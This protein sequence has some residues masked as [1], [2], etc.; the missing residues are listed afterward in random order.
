MIGDEIKNSIIAF[1][2]AAEIDY[3]YSDEKKL[4]LLRDQ[5]IN[6][7]LA[8]VNVFVELRATGFIVI[9]FSP[10]NAPKETQNE[11]VRYL[12]MIN[13]S[14]TY[15]YFSLDYSDGEVK[16]LHSLDCTDIT[17]LTHNMIYLP[18]VMSINSFEKYGDGLCSLMMG[19][20]DAETE[21]TKA[22]NT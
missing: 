5:R 20:S 18:L 7:K 14:K 10:R 22:E 9:S 16:W 6:S 21:F 4:F 17:Q 15:G 2:N 13:H 3:L 12:N 11:V 1:F 8:T 19:F